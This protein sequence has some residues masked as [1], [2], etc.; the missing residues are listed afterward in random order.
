[1]LNRKLIHADAELSALLRRLPRQAFSQPLRQQALAARSNLR[2]ALR[3]LRRA[4]S[5][6]GDA[7]QRQATRRVSGCDTACAKTQALSRALHQADAAATQGFVLAATGH[8]LIDQWRGGS[9]RTAP[10]RWETIRARARRRIGRGSIPRRPR[11]PTS[12][13]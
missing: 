5:E 2:E 4:L 3:V 6:H 9:P 12:P 11:Q 10:S 7:Q 1:M 8:L 13:S